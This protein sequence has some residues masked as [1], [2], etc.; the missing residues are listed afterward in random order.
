MAQGKF[1]AYYRVS[2]D[3]QGRSGLG[4][5]AQKKAVR[6]Y[7]EGGRWPLVQEF[8]EVESGK[9]NDRPEL[10]KALHL[11]KVTGSK[12]IIAKL[13]RLSRNASFLLSLRDSGVRFVCA[14]NPEANE[15][16]IGILAVVAEDE[17][18]RISDRTRTALQA[19]KA[20]GVKLGNPNGARAIK[21]L[22]NKAAVSRIQEIAD[23]RVS[24]LK[25]VIEAI[26]SEGFTT[27][28]A[29]ARQLTLRGVMTPRGGKWHRT[30][31]RNLLNR[32]E[33]QPL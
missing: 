29:M 33:H 28:E 6:D 4:L 26:R 8:T 19:A 23:S 17:R 3:R 20:R 30:S 1:I 22:G 32:L 2:T 13:D 18:Q 5:E 27:L 16:T 10:S 24:D 7:L 25:P 11:C 14:D 9:R 12:L 21:T 15:L 31:V